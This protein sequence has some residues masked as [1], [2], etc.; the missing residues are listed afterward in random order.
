[1]DP[2]N[3]PPTAAPT[4][5]N[6]L[7]E[8]RELPQLEALPQYVKVVL[9]MDLVESVRLMAGNELAV[10]DQLRGFVQHASQA[11]LP[12]HQGRLVK[13]LGDGIMAEFDCPRKAVSAARQLHHYFAPAN[14]KLPPDERLYLRAGLNATHVYVDGMDIYGSGVNLAARVAALAGPGETMVTAEVRDAL[15]DGLDAQVQDMGECYLKHVAQPVRAF[16]VGEAGDKPILAAL[17]DSENLVRPSLAVIPFE[18][19]SNDPSLFSVGNLIA[20]G[21][22]AQ[23]GRT[24]DLRIISRLSTAAFQGRLAN[25]GEIKASLGANYVLCGGYWPT[26][27]GPGAPLLVTVE[28][29]STKTSEVVW[30]DRF[31]TEVSDL[32]Q[33]QSESLGRIV[34]AS[35]AAILNREVRDTQAESLPTLA[36]YSLQLSGVSLMHRSSNLEFERGHQALEALVERHRNLA[37]GHAWLAKWHVLRVIR[38]NSPD[39]AR[40]AALALEACGKA[41]DASPAHGLALAVRGYAMT[42]LLSDPRAAKDCLNQAVVQSPNEAH[43]WLYLSVWA[44]H[45]DDSRDAVAYAL[46]AKE[47]SPLDPHTYFLET[48]LANA[49][50][51]IGQCDL[52]I[53]AATRALRLDKSHAPTLRVLILAQVESDRVE[54]ARATC[55]RLLLVAPHLTIAAYQQMGNPDSPARQRVVKALRISGVPEFF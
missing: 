26:H 8:L 46:R 14:A 27:G 52:A 22:I 36:A 32:L 29:C 50:A 17:S 38:G 2:I 4:E 19:R 39:P 1:M 3:T 31:T 13:S 24:A 18:N 12:K 45:W 21:V 6:Q 42:Q 53:E 20:D 7:S 15:I 10:I 34:K 37:H 23:L 30:S 16:R 33:N 35:Y 49:Y 54:E 25:V 48:I 44:T 9:V 51:F 11:V 5:L 40:D 43:A 41:L 55:K 47:L 28:L